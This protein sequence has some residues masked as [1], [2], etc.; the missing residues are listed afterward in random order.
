MSCRYVMN[1]RSTTRGS[2][3]RALEY[4]RRQNVPDRP[5]STASSFYGLVGFFFGFFSFQNVFLGNHD[6][7]CSQ[8]PMGPNWFWIGLILILKVP[9]GEL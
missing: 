1:G 7:K 2:V 6:H 3:R 9:L 8:V 5:R 4:G